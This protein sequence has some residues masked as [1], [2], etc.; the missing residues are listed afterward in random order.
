MP[1]PVAFEAGPYETILAERR[2]R[3]AVVTLNRPKL[4]NALNQQ[5]MREV[6]S[7]LTAADADPGIGCS[8]LTG[9]D[10]AFAAG[11]DIKEMSGLDFTDVVRADWFAGWDGLAA[12]R[13]P[14]IAAV[15]GLALGGGCELA[16]MCDVILAGD[17]ARFGQP[18]IRLG[19]IPGM[20]GSQRLARL[21]GRPKAMEMCLTGRTMD[22]DEAER[23]GLVSRVVPADRLLEEAVAVAEVIAGMS[24]PVAA[25]VKQCIN[26][27]DEVG[28]G[29]GVRADR[30]MA[31]ATFATVDRKE[32]MDA[33][34][35]KRA[36]VFRNR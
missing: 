32:G 13:K 29:E 33:F 8:V 2:G 23:A 30:R 36:P 6:V 4:L 35:A 15:R 17:D 16:M 26:R 11:A 12:L 21:V 1:D 18:E 27:A 7:A 25:M 24:Q 31:H 3:V 22:A 19:T 5:A 28:L 20:G 10:K 14:V 34:V 9:S